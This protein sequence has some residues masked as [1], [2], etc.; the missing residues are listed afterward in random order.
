MTGREGRGAAGRWREPPE[1]CP[2]LSTCLCPEMPRDKLHHAVG[3][4]RDPETARRGGGAPQGPGLTT[5]APSQRPPST[6]HGTDPPAEPAFLTHKIV[7]HNNVWGRCVT[8]TQGNSNLPNVLQVWVP[9]QIPE[10]APQGGCV[11]R[12]SPEPVAAAPSL[13]LPSAHPTR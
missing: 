8:L 7:R 11:G 6:P 3:T 4:G 13:C 9:S 12:A 1:A 5:E 10:S 2:L